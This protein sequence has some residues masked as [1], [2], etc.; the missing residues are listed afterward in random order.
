MA[1]LMCLIYNLL[2]FHILKRIKN[3]FFNKNFDEIKIPQKCLQIR[4]FKFSVYN[5]DK[6]N[7]KYY[8]ITEFDFF[9]LILFIIYQEK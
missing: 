5:E 3:R 1:S 4:T 2:W 9:F 8:N 6:E 7:C